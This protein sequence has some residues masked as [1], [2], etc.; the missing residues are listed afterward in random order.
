MSIV[1]LQG[2]TRVVLNSVSWST[3][4]SLLAE[5]DH[6]GT[7]FTYDRGC[8]EIMSPSDK[9]ER[10]KTLLGHVVEMTAV[11]WNIPIRS[12]GSTTLKS[13]LKQR[14][15]EPD[16]CYYVAN[17]ASVRG[18]DEIDL[19]ISP[20]PD[21]AIEVDISSSSLDQLRIYADLGVPEVWLYD[22]ATLKV[23]QLRKEGEYTPQPRSP[24][25][26]FLP[27]EEVERFLACRNETD[28]TTWIRSFREWVKTLGR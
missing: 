14:G 7:R 28:E 2:E 5:T 15:L 27:I 23:Y 22:G 13:E 20:P 1:D 12:G 16:E 10:L 17:E 19:M 18:C 24:S 25:F 8:L 3:F 21:L 6:R 4:E 26:P 9:H 11:E